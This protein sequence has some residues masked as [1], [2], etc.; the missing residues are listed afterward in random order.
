LAGSDLIPFEEAPDDSGVGGR[1]I[2]PIAPINPVVPSGADFAA[3]MEQ[4]DAYRESQIAM[5]Q[6]GNAAGGHLAQRDVNDVKIEKA[7]FLPAEIK[8]ET[9]LARLFRKLKLELKTDARLTEFI[10]P[11]QIFT[12]IVEQETIIGL[13]GKLQAA[14]RT[15]QLQMAMRQKE[16]IYGLLRKNM[17]SETFQTIYAILMAKI[18]EEFEISVRP[19]VVAGASRDEIDQL[20]KANIVSPIVGELEQ[21]GDFEGVAITTVRGMI[22]FLTGN[23]HLV[24]H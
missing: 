23:C 3:M 6:V 2:M 9:Q 7:T 12:R 20:V 24:W 1:Q 11:L 16:A 15:D 5:A 8:V 21:C 18:F 14:N 19:A 22:Y 4:V 10:E 13:E 17:F